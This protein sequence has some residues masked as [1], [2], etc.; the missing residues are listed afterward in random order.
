MRWFFLVVGLLCAAAATF[1][2][3]AKA[4]LDCICLGIAAV[5]WA[6]LYGGTR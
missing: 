3:V 4:S 5:F 2:W 1:A 6:T